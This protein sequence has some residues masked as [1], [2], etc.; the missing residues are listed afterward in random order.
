MHRLG[1]KILRAIAGQE[2]MALQERHRFQRLAAL[3]L[4]KDACEYRTEPLGGDGGKYLAHVGVARDPRHPVAGGQIAL[5]P[6]LVTGEARG[7]FAGKHRERGH[8]R[9]R[10][11]NV[12]LAQAVMRDVSKTVSH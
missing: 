11:S 7:G 8:Q 10:E 5:N 4:P 3:E 6:L 12:W 9:I 1:S 2:I